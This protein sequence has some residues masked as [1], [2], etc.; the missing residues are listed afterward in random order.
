MFTSWVS[1]VKIQ[2]KGAKS[3]TMTPMDQ[4]LWRTHLLDTNT[5]TGKLDLFFFV[6]HN[7]LLNLIVEKKLV[8]AHLSSTGPNDLLSLI[9]GDD[10]TGSQIVN[11]KGNIVYFP[12]F[13]DKHALTVS[14][15]RLLGSLYGALIDL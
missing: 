6:S 8:N 3:G 1:I 7:I 14:S 5:H 11:L 12:T 10:K 4:V 2:N 15:I 9:V 13:I